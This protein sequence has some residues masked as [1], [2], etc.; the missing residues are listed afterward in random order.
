M[1]EGV[2]L[3]ESGPYAP[4]L[5]IRVHRVEYRQAERTAKPYPG[6]EK[7]ETLRLTRD[8]H[9]GELPKKSDA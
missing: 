2:L 1:R 4:D 8:H 6:L 9:F 7:F 5:S 3:V